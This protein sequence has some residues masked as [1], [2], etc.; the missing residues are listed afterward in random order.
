[1]D[2]LRDFDAD[3]EKARKMKHKRMQKMLE[4]KKAELEAKKLAM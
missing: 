4:K 1:M 3:D 2:I